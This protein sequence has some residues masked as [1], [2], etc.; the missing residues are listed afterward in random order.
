V[1]KA[2]AAVKL[3]NLLESKDI[4]I[5]AA[6]TLVVLDGHCLGK[7]KDFF[8]AERF[9]QGL[10]GKTHSVITG[11][12]LLDLGRNERY[13]GFEESKVTFRRL[14]SNEIHDYI[15]SGEPM[16]KAGAY[17][18]QGGGGPFVSR[19]EGSYSNVVGL[20]M[21][22]LNRVLTERNWHVDRSA[23]G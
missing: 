4:L 1:R 16:D 23:T 8:E 3:P 15:Q 17:A 9:L 7:P 10:S 20:P 12:C 6:D 21:E 22:H 14:S 11:L 18:I 13:A 19:L 5:L 2:E